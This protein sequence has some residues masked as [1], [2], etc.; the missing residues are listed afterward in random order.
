MSKEAERWRSG[1]STCSSKSGVSSPFKRAWPKLGG[2]LPGSG[3]GA[4]KGEMFPRLP[5]TFTPALSLNPGQGRGCHC[6]EVAPLFPE[7]HAKRPLLHPCHQLEGTGLSL[8]LPEAAAAKVM[9]GAWEGPV[10]LG[11]FL[12]TPEPDCHLPEGYKGLWNFLSCSLGVF[13]CPFSPPPPPPSRSE[14]SGGAEYSLRRSQKKLK[15]KP[16]ST[17]F[18]PNYWSLE[19]LG[20][21]VLPI[22]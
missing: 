13:S 15:N 17:F 9:A 18:S 14:G 10:S 7:S 16:T 1:S 12:G 4:L 11:L 21:L 5:P 3:S 2:M 8:P 6:W 22:Q 20:A 19:R